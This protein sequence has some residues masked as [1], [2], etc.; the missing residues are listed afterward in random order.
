MGGFYAPI[1][2]V[3]VVAKSIKRALLV[4]KLESLAMSFIKSVDYKKVHALTSKRECHGGR[5]TIVEP[6]RD[7]LRVDHTRNH[8]PV[9]PIRNANDC[10]YYTVDLNDRRNTPVDVTERPR[11]NVLKVDIL[12]HVSPKPSS[13]SDSPLTCRLITQVGREA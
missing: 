1:P 11:A 12:R 10:L 5:W 9:S 3:I 8:R 6:G 2:L 13:S 7:P 4:C